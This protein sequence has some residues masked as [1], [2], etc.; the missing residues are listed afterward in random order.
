MFKSILSAII[1]FS[2][3][4]AWGSRFFNGHNM[5]VP[6]NSHQKL[7]LID[8]YYF[9]TDNPGELERCSPAMNTKSLLIQKSS[10]DS[11]KPFYGKNFRFEVELPDS[12]TQRIF[13]GKLDRFI[14]KKLSDDGLYQAYKFNFSVSRR[15]AASFDYILPAEYGW[16]IIDTLLLNCDANISIDST[17]IDFSELLEKYELLYHELERVTNKEHLS[18]IDSLQ[19]NM[20][21]NAIRRVKSQVETGRKR[22]IGTPIRFQIYTS[23]QNEQRMIKRALAKKMANTRFYL[24][25]K[26]VFGIIVFLAIS[27]GFLIILI[28]IFIRKK[29]G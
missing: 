5:S 4:F 16:E 2:V 9:V 8:D 1:C 12:K 27:Q 3:C 6:L 23:E 26:L 22:K 20:Y 18:Y 14:K 25:T 29:S 15:S 21:K 10:L 11:S 28:F 19:L 13:I 7:F 17:Y 24:T